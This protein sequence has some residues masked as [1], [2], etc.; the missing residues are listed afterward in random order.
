MPAFLKA[1]LVGANT[2]KFAAVLESVFTK[3]ALVTAA[4]KIENEVSL[5]ATPT[6]VGVG[7]GGTTGTGSSF[8]QDEITKV[9]PTIA[10]KNKFLMFLMLFIILNFYK[11]KLQKLNQKYFRKVLYCYITGVNRKI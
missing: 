6:T 2:V 7:V 3:P 9:V 4:T 11:V 8:L 1:V 5:C 10:S